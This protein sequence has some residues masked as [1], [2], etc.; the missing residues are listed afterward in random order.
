MPDDLRWSWCNNNRN[1]VHDK[2]S[3][4][5]HPQISPVHGKKLPTM[6]LVPGAQKVGDRC[7]EGFQSGSFPHP[8]LQAGRNFSLIF[9]VGIWWSSRRQ[10]EGVGVPLWLSVSG[11]FHCQT[12]PPWAS[13]NMSITVQSFPHGTGSHGGFPLWVSDLEAT[14]PCVFLSVSSLRGSGL[15]QFSLLRIQGE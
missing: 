7:S 12:C 8:Q 15:P 5:K 6:K 1:K 10:T 11:V 2:C 9:T 13:S 3:V 4:L 14:A